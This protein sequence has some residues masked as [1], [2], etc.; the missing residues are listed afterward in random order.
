M[1]INSVPVFARL[2]DD[3]DAWSMLTNIIVKLLSISTE[4]LFPSYLLTALNRIWI[5]I[6]QLFIDHQ[7]PH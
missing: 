4:L 1:E 6:Y 3:F 2:I 7:L 5:Q